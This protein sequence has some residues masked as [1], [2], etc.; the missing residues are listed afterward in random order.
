MTD[1]APHRSPHV[2]VGAALGGHPVATD[3]GVCR[4][5]SAD[6]FAEADAV[7]SAS[8]RCRTS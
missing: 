1:I 2:L 5:T 7:R 6:K 8:W 3:V 4:P